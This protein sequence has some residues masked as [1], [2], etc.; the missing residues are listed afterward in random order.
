MSLSNKYATDNTV[1]N[2]LINMLLNTLRNVLINMPLN[3]MR[4]VCYTTI[5]L[6]QLSQQLFLYDH[7]S[8]RWVIKQKIYI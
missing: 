1:R 7:V 8:N 4:N 2:V 6:R 5:K 3:T